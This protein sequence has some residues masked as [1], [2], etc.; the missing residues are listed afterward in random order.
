MSWPDVVWSAAVLRGID[1]RARTEIEA[2][3]SSRA[4]TKG[5]KIFASGE[6]ADAF[7]VVEEG[8][9]AVRAIPRGEGEI[10]II[11]EVVRGESFGE[12]ST[13]RAGSTRQMEA[14]CLE[15]TRVAVIPAPVFTRAAE[16]GGEGEAS[17]N[18]KK[19]LRRAATLDLLRTTSF[20]RKLADREIEVLL[21][22]V[23]HVELA[24]G[25]YLFRERDPA[26][27][28]YFIADGMVQLQV[29]DDE[30]LHVRAYLGRGDVVGDGEISTGE[31]RRTSAVASGATW[32]LGVPRSVFIAV[33]ARNPGLLQ[34]IRRVV[35]ENEDR[36]LA[37]A[38]SANTTQHVFKDLYRL[39]VARSLL[40]IDQ[41]SCVRC[42]HCAWSCASVHDDGVSRLVRRGDKVVSKL[43]GGGTASL[44]LPNSCQHCENPS[45]MPE[46]PTGAIGRDPRGEVFIREDLCTGCGNCAK[47]CPWD[48]IQMAARLTVETGVFGSVGGSPE[49]AVKCDLC[50]DRADGPACVA[51]CPTQSILRIRPSAVLLDVRDAL[52]KQGPAELMPR[53]APAWPWVAGAA[54]ASVA[55]AALPAGTSKLGTGILSGLLMVALAAYAFIKRR[56][57]PKLRPHFI[58]HLVMGIVV[59]GVVLAH[60]GSRVPSNLGGSLFLAFFVAAG[61]GVLGALAYRFVPKSLSRIEKRGALPEDLPGHARDLEARIFRELSG[62]SEL[63]KTIFRKILDPYRRSPLSPILLVARATTLAKEQR[64]LRSEIEKIIEGRSGDKLQGLDDLIAVVVEGRAVTAQRFLQG[65]LRGWLALHVA[66]SVLVVILLVLHAVFAVAYR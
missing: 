54:L 55:I 3:G 23:S 45:C 51:S 61:L 43:E 10:R 16:R 32:A 24:R 59:V 37:I 6:P 33:D 40:V 49:V 57:A 17:V 31:P 29:E 14:V 41:E 22:S 44:L 7:F 28:V 11:R 47:G 19:T 50:S 63:V 5:E 48:N 27:H 1:D 12:E 25:E 53:P 39:N 58:A 30:K 56:L 34:G 46:C 4:C 64:R 38:V 42:G 9:V 13:L 66:V 15:T 26:T 62:R 20:A 18:L 65:V 36:L 35:E 2:A 8:R 21:D 52:G 60:A